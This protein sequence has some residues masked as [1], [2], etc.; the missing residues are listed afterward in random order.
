MFNDAC[1]EAF[2]DI[3]TKVIS[4]PITRA[5]NLSLPFDIMCDTSNFS[6]GSFLGQRCE[7][8]FRAIYYVS[9]TL[10]EAQ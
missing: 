6:I 1:L 2:V 4:S 8:I 9:R 10:N 3:K 7:K 5:S